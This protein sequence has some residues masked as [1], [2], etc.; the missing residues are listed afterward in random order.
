MGGARGRLS[1]QG[2]LPGGV[3]FVHLLVQGADV[4]EQ[5]AQIM[6]M[7]LPPLD[8]LVNNN[9]VEAFLGRLGNEFFGQ[10]DVLLA[11][12]AEAVEAIL[13][14]REAPAELSFS[15]GPKLRLGLHLLEAPLRFPRELTA[16][17]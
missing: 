2:V 16:S 4:L 11:G 13:R 15:L 8:L 17:P 9:P 5:L 3:L 6:Q 14:E 7:V 12:E 10:G 1:G